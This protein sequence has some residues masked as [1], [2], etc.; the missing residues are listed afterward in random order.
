MAIS[1]NVG[2]LHNILGTIRTTDS[3]LNTKRQVKAVLKGNQVLNGVIHRTKG[4]VK[5]LLIGNTPFDAL[6]FK[7]FGPVDGHNL[8]DLIKNLNFAKKA[9]KPVLIHVK[10]TKGKGFSFAMNKIS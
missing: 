5:R 10:T 6:G 9:D 7:Y 2:A 1:P 4:S 8:N 3:Y